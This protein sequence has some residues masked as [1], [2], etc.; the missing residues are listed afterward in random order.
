M[1]SVVAVL[2]QQVGFI[3]LEGA[4]ALVSLWGTR[5]SSG[6]V[7]ARR[8]APIR[9]FPWPPRGFRRASSRATWRVA[10]P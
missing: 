3:L 9:V 8:P 6:V 1:L 5:R 2:D 4:W 10:V 7:A